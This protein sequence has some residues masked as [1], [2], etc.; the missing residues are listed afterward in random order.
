MK[1]AHK[2]LLSRAFG[3]AQSQEPDTAL[4]QLAA[5]AVAARR[6]D[7]NEDAIPGSSVLETAA[8]PDDASAFA[9]QVLAAARA[10]KTGRYGDNK[11]FIAHV[12]RQLGAGGAAGDF[13]DFKARLVAAHL[14]GLLSLS[15]A[16]L[17]EAMAADDV[18]ASE[19]FHG[20]S[21]FHF[22]RIED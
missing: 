5:K 2:L 15:R 14:A 19:T 16:D 7:A 9:A 21:T 8:P 11:V 10:S 13:E 17:V 3:V 20:E 1:A 6:A 12:F 18:S 22:V 4:A